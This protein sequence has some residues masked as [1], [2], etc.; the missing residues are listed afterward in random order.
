MEL[1]NRHMRSGAATPFD[2]PLPYTGASGHEHSGGVR[3]PGWWWCRVPMSCCVAWGLC[4]WH[5]LRAGISP[6][7]L[8]VPLPPPSRARRWR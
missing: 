8:R 5:G 2:V 1:F 4:H 3:P 6:H 7:S